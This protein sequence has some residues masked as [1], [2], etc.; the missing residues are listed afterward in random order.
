MYVVHVIIIIG[1][2]VMMLRIKYKKV[3][4]E[5]QKFCIAIFQLCT[6]IPDIDFQ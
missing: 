4:L 6:G 1:K 5:F 3:S 2:I